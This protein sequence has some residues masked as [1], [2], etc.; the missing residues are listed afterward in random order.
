MIPFQADNFPG[1]LLH[2]I[3]KLPEIQ[4]ITRHIPEE[5]HLLYDLMFNPPKDLPGF[6]DYIQL[7]AEESGR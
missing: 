6:P 4:D 5:M 7:T 1:R 2:K 3:E